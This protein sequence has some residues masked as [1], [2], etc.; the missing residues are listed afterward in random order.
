MTSRAIDKLCEA[1]DEIDGADSPIDVYRH[2][3]N[4]RAALS[5]LESFVK[6]V[7]R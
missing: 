3:D 1:L 4:A 7:S 2:T 5:D 6:S